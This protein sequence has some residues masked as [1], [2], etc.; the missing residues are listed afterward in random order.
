[1][2]VPVGFYQTVVEKVLGRSRSV[3]YVMPEA[4]P[5]RTVFHTLAAR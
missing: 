4:A 5:L 2:V 1:V 3:V